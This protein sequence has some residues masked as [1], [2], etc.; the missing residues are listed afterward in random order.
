M[1]RNRGAVIII[2]EDQIAL[3]KRIKGNEV[4][5]V[6]PGGGIEEGETSEKATEREVYEELAVHIKIQNLVTKAEDNGTQYYYESYITDGVFGS[7]KGEEFKGADRGQY[8]PLWV[9]MKEIMNLNV[10]HD[11]VAKIVLDYYEHI[12]SDNIQ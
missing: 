1:S 12:K 11:Y 2:Q 8:I 9:P 3:M 5:F 4:Y 6:F 10:K 7:G